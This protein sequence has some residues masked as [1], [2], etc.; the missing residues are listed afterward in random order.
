MTR[1]LQPTI[2]RVPGGP[3][4]LS[5]ATGSLV[6]QLVRGRRD[7][8]TPIMAHEPPYDV[9][10]VYRQA[11]QDRLLKGTDVTPRPWNVSDLVA[12]RVRP[13][14]IMLDN[15]CGTAYKSLRHAAGLRLL[16]GIEPNAAMIG[17][18]IHNA[19][20]AGAY[21]V[22]FV[23]GDCDHL[24]VADGA[25]DVVVSFL[26]PHNTAELHRV[27]KVG[28][29]AVVERVGDRDKVNIKECFGSDADGPRGQLLHLEAGA[30]AHD[31]DQQFR[32]LFPIVEMHNGFWDT[33]YTREQVL[34]LLAF[35]PTIRQYDV[36]ADHS[37]VEAMTAALLV[38]G[39]VRTTQ[40]R[41]LVVAQKG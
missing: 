32:A 10:Y 11:Y 12:S 15:G 4:A 25:A 33:A 26:A 27:L 20:A 5:R 17:A 6:R 19:M 7:H 28:G 21:N 40:N 13:G 2:Y 23:S 8:R 30:R 35:T 36:N 16:I 9:R 34:A 14:A 38:N 39:V 22:C 41:V 24:P 1:S 37:A 18:A 29:W 3:R 31:M